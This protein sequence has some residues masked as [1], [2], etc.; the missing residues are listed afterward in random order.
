MQTIDFFIQ[1]N[2]LCKPSECAEIVEK[3]KKN[4][5]FSVANKKKSIRWQTHC[6]FI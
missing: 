3:N 1:D 4:E 2:I 6:S 5:R